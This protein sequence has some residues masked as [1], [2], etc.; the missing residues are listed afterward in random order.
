MTPEEL[1][2]A[3]EKYNIKLVPVPQGPL[4]MGPGKTH[5]TWSAGYLTQG[6]YN[7]YVKSEDS[8]WG[9]SPVEAVTNLLSKGSIDRENWKECNPNDL[10]LLIESLVAGGLK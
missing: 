8:A 1:L 9:T 2:A 7:N 10:A 3:I 5:L 6:T 4:G